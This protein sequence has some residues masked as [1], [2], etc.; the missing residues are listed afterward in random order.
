ME[1]PSSKSG[2][3]DGVFEN[4][5]FQTPGNRKRNLLPMYD[6]RGLVPMGISNNPILRAFKGFSPIPPTTTVPPGL[7]A[8][9]PAL[10]VPSANL[11]GCSFVPEPDN[12]NARETAK[13]HDSSRQ[14][15]KIRDFSGD[16]S[17]SP[18]IFQ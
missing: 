7:G 14:F 6:L 9:Q 13:Y 12:W 8:P 17:R 3:T 16:G 4:F 5:T 2:V 10:G 18:E 1:C 11:I 15:L